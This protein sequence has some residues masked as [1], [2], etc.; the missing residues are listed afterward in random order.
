VVGAVPLEKAKVLDVVF[1]D[2]VI[3]ETGVEP[4]L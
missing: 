2:A 4:V 3:G 1:L